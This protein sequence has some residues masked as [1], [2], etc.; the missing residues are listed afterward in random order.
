[1]TEESIEELF[2]MWSITTMASSAEDEDQTLKFYFYTR[3]T[4]D[5]SYFCVEMHIDKSEHQMHLSIKA[6][7]EGA[8]VHLKNYILQLLSVNELIEVEGE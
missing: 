5:N 3:D 2:K 7:S 1:M 4:R 6:A 8:A